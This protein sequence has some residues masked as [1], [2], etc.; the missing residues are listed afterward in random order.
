[1]SAEAIR[2][3]PIPTVVGDAGAGDGISTAGV[4]DKYVDF[5]GITGGASYQIQGCSLAPGA[6]VV[7]SVQMPVPLL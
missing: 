4:G 6:S 5:S 3:F 1:M 7:P 2:S